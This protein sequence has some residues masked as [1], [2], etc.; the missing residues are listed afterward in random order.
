MIQIDFFELSILIEACW[1]G[2][3]ILRA[4]VMQKAVDE[5]YHKLTP[6]ER[7]RLYSYTIRVLRDKGA[8]MEMDKE[9]QEIFLARYNPANQYEVYYV[10]NGEKKSRQAFKWNNK[11]YINRTTHIIPEVITQVVANT[12]TSA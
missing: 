3:T 6:N 2:G 8:V 9:I 4:S 5:W 1:S 10:D 12:P 11:Y 7:E